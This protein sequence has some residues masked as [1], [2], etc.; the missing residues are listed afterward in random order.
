MVELQ[1]AADPAAN[2]ELM[3]E[4]V[5][6]MLEGETDLIAALANVSAVLNSYL[7]DINWV[8]FYLLKGTEL[9][10]GPFQGKPAC[11]RIGEGKGV[12]GR[13]ALDQKPLIVADV[14]RFPGHIACDSASASEIVIPLFKGGRVFGVLDVDSPHP[15]RFTDLEADYLSRAG[16]LIGNF[17]ETT[18]ITEVI[19][20]HH[21][22]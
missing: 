17:L 3:T 11:T 10:L 15:N 20:E 4:T 13:A 14:H 16:T 6:A 19:H 21:T 18:S 2:L 5:K 8:G 1:R 7:P 9:V 22:F 12:C